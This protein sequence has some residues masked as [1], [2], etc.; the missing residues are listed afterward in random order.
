MHL[1]RRHLYAHGGEVIPETIRFAALRPIVSPT[2]SLS[3]ELHLRQ[4]INHLN[5]A[6][7][8]CAQGPELWKSQPG[9]TKTFEGARNIVTVFHDLARTAAPNLDYLVDALRRQ[10]CM[11]RDSNHLAAAGRD[12]VAA[13]DEFVIPDWAFTIALIYDSQNIRC[14]AHIPYLLPGDEGPHYLSFHFATLLFPSQCPDPCDVGS[15]V[16]GRYRVA[17]ALLFLQQHISGLAALY[18]EVAWAASDSTQQL[19]HGRP[20]G[21]M[22]LAWRNLRSTSPT[23]SETYHVL[24]ASLDFA[25]R[26]AAYHQK[27]IGDGDICSSSDHTEPEAELVHQIH[28]WYDECAASHCPGAE[29]RSLVLSHSEGTHCHRGRL[30]TAHCGTGDRPLGENSDSGQEGKE[31]DPYLLELLG[32]LSAY[33]AAQSEEQTSA[34]DVET[35]EHIR[36]KHAW[37]EYVAADLRLKYWCVPRLSDII[38]SVWLNTVNV[39][40]YHVPI[41]I[42]IKLPQALHVTRNLASR[43]SQAHPGPDPNP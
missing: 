34:D 26:L 15:F 2:T 14:M 29:H 42:L 18:Q 22:P 37:E 19:A 43:L 13:S 1:L 25:A 24:Q 9:S 12:R 35:V 39:A 7:L 36:V 21:K 32:S 38:I 20:I 6:L 40:H 3:L 23:V 17:M 27:V 5:P 8:L 11:R 33:D 4:P 31:L 28:K 16:E 41:V 30:E 10:Q